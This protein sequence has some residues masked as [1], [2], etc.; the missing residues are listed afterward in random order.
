MV[1]VTV[2]HTSTGHTPDSWRS[3]LSNGGIRD[4][5]ASPQAASSN[6]TPAPI[7]TSSTWGHMLA[8]NPS[9]AQASTAYCIW[10]DGIIRYGSRARS[11]D[12]LDQLR[13]QVVTAQA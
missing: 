10:R 2:F 12:L 4:I 9:A 8:A 13:Q 1:T 5:H 6:A 3:S 7:Q 11:R